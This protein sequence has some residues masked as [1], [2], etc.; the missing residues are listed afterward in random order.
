M[1]S[2]MSTEQGMLEYG[3]TDFKGNKWP[4]TYVDRYNQMSK[5]I[6]KTANMEII[7]GSLIEQ[8]RQFLLDQRHRLFIEFISWF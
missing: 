6:N 7:P 8:E 3:F 2:Y 5:E 1:Q 4:D